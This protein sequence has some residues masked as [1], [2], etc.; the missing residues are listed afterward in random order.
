MEINNSIAKKL[1]AFRKQVGKLGLHLKS[2][3]RTESGSRRLLHLYYADRDGHF[4]GSLLFSAAELKYDSVRGIYYRLPKVK[5]NFFLQ[6]WRESGLEAQSL[7]NN[8]GYVVAVPGPI[9]E[10]VSDQPA[11]PVISYMA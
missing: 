10:F 11:E 7:E 1:A 9:P 2:Q 4:H 6:A 8:D 5:I 3:Q